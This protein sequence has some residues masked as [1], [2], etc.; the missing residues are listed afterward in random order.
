M[1]IRDRR[2]ADDAPS[3][4]VMGEII[5]SEY[6]NE[7]IVLGGHIDSW[8]VGQGAHDDG[9]GC[10]ASWQAVKLIKDLGLKPKRTIRAVMWTNE[11]NGLRGG[12]AYRDA[13]FDELD[14]HI[15]AMESDAGVFKPSGFGFSGPDESLKILQDIGTLLY[16]I[17]SGKI[18][19]GGGG[20]DI[21]PIMREGVPG[22][23]LKVDGSRY[24]WYHHTNADTFDKVDK[25][26]FNRCVASMAVMAYVVA[27]MDMKL[28]R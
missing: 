10:V 8:D 17:D 21:G 13:H 27:D 24:F 26:E 4:N 3:Q 7:V 11:E 22:M 18:T 20:A 28:P 9:G 14:N 6:P 23:G 2:F 16:R 12:N 15:L 1:C 19:K 5:G 25:D